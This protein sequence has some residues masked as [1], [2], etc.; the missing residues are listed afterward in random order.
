M[1]TRVQLSVLL[2]VVAAFVTGCGQKSNHD[3]V[4][5]QARDRMNLVNAQ[6]TYNQAEQYFETGQFDKALREIN[7]A[8][9]RYPKSCTFYVL[10]GRIH[11]E[12]KRLEQAMTSLKSGIQAG[13]DACG[14]DSEDP[15][16]KQ[17]KLI[18]ESD[19]MLKSALADAHYYTGIVYQ[20]WSD[21]EQAYEHYTL[22]FELDQGKVDYLLAAA[23]SQI[24]LGEYEQAQ[25]LV[26]PRLAYFEHNAAL[27]QLLGQIALLQGNPAI[28][29]RLYGEA[30][31]LSPDDNSL[32]EDLVWAQYAAEMYGDCLESIK[33]LL[34][35]ANGVPSTPRSI[36]GRPTQSGLAIN[37]SSSASDRVDLKHLQARCLTMLGRLSNAREMYLEVARLKPAEVTVWT[38]LGTVC[39]ELGDYRRVAVCSVHIIALAPERF[40]GY[41][42][43]GIN[44]RQ[45]NNFS[46][47]VALF[48][49]ATEKTTDSAMPW[50]LLGQT[51]EQAGDF[52]GAK[53][54]Y[55]Q[56]L[57]VDPRSID[58]KH[59]LARLEQTQA[60]TV[61]STP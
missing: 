50:L 36:N 54:A 3:L 33:S 11:L 13:R 56:A 19:Q 39:W 43:R 21:D 1:S 7:A 6:V 17:D 52:D 42:L 53:E 37:G 29:A 2:F 14:I 26:E 55:S 45:K 10:Q 48:T 47:A 30:R 4:R 20:R 46:Q 31:L 32:L 12:A 28:A 49:K 5:E 24:A 16:E 38:E 60:V 61:V 18:L 15:V 27:H 40:E 9:A 35:R 59:L 41:M 23:E 44:E 58:A 57:H 34:S 22:A 51:L 8:I 25:A